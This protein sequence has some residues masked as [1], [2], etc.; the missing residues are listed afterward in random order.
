M[1]KASSKNIDSESTLLV[2]N[3]FAR[4]PDKVATMPLIVGI[5]AADTPAAIERALP[6]E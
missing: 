6:P 5:V 1:V 2:K 4:T 3:E